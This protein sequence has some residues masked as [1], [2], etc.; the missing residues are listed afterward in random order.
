[1]SVALTNRTTT[2]CRYTPSDEETGMEDMSRLRK[3]PSVKHTGGDG[4]SGRQGSSRRKSAIKTTTIDANHA[5]CRSPVLLERY[6]GILY[7]V[8]ISTT[9]SCTTAVLPLAF[10]LILTGMPGYQ[11]LKPLLISSI[12]VAGLNMCWLLFLALLLRY[13]MNQ[14]RFCMVAPRRHH[15][16]KS[17][18]IGLPTLVHSTNQR[19]APTKQTQ[20]QACN[21]S[22]K[23]LAEP[24]SDEI[25]RLKLPQNSRSDGEGRGTHING[26]TI[27]ATMAARVETMPI[28]RG[29]VRSMETKGLPMRRQSVWLLA[30]TYSIDARNQEKERQRLKSMSRASWLYCKS[31]G[32]LHMIWWT[33]NKYR[34]Q[35]SETCIVSSPE[36]GVIA[37]SPD[38]KEKD[39]S[40]HRA[41]VLSKG[42]GRR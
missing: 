30:L 5:C 15:R 23:N 38:E 18:Q 25:E 35:R 39:C 6:D 12:T 40:R 11:S 27:A 1:M 36:S 31:A 2:S 24:I 8:Y 26:R 20:P 22:G 4:S 29:T 14:P 42:H 7:G 3:Q 17:L 16:E 19:L 33:A 34:Q 41:V 21:E 37:N 32:N 9:L 10:L 13:K 28:K